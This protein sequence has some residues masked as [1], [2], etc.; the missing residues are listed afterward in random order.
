MK[1]RKKN[2][3]FTLIEIMIAMGILALVLLGLMSATL[4]AFR[5]T[6]ETDNKIQAINAL[7]TVLNQVKAAKSLPGD[8]PGNVTGAFPAGEF[9]PDE[10]VMPNQTITIAYEDAL[11]NPLVVTV[12]IQYAIALNHRIKDGDDDGVVDMRSERLSTIF[13]GF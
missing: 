13:G 3:G 12:E 6:Q 5:L 11:A 4:R 10:E 9:T 1:L 7:Q 2:K 8:F